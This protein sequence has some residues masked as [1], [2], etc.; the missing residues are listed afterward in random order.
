MTRTKAML[1]AGTRLAD[2]LTVG[3]L[4]MN[5]PVDRVRGVD[6]LAELLDFR[7]VVVVR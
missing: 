2:Y 3:F 4:A 6:K 5:C 1:S 7:P